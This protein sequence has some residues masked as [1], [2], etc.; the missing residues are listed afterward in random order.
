MRDLVDNVGN[1]G[2]HYVYDA[3]GEVISGDTAQT[4]YLYTGRELDTSIGLQYNRARWYDPRV[5]RW[6]SEDPIGFAGGDA[7]LTRYVGNAATNATDPSGLDSEH[8]RGARPSTSDAHER[9]GG[10]DDQL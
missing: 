5:G 2:T 9:P 8:T 1:L 4:R 6:I 7:N 3:F 10:T